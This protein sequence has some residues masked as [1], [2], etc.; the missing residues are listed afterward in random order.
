MELI[1]LPLDIFYWTL[2][3]LFHTLSFY[4]LS[5]IEPDLTWL[6]FYSL[7]ALLQAGFCYFIMTLGFSP[8]LVFLIIAVPSLCV[9][10]VI[11]YR[12]KTKEQP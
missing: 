9:Y 7:Y 12:A 6:P 11:R 10:A 5:S 2:F 4:K 1:S 8:L 3:I